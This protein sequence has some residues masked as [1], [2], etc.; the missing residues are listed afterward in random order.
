MIS[1]GG[2]LMVQII[3]ASSSSSSIKRDSS[4]KKDDVALISDRKNGFSA[5]PVPVSSSKDVSD[6]LKK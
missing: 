1:A 6:I 4:S 5:S 3:G 2:S